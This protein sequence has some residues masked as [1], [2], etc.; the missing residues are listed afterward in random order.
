MAQML[1]EL[2]PGVPVYANP[3]RQGTRFPAFFVTWMPSE[4]AAQIGGRWLRTI[5]VDL[6]YLEELDREDQYDRFLAAAETLEEHMETIPMGGGVLRTFGRKWFIRSDDLH[7]QFKLKVRVSLPSA[8][9]RI[10]S[11]EAVNSEVK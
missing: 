1:G 2:F 11:I 9:P 10:Q 5:G 8:V 6:T 7:Y 4:T 3:N